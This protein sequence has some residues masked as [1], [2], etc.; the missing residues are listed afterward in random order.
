[1]NDDI[2]QDLK[3]FIAATVHQEIVSAENSLDVKM[4]DISNKID[5]VDKKID[6]RAN[7]LLSAIADTTS[8]RFESIEE[9]V[10]NLD[11]RVTKLASNPA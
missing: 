2:I 7:E 3:Q 9:D 5:D 1:M 4:S 8:G 11:A 6:D 10:K